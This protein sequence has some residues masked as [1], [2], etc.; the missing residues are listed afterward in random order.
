MA[1]EKK[2]EQPEVKD[3]PEAKKEENKE[4]NKDVEALSKKIESLSQQLSFLQAENSKLKEETEQWKNKYYLAFADL[5]NTRKTIE[6][7]HETFVKYRSQ[8]FLEKMLPALD[9]FEMALMAEPKDPAI[10]NYY[11]G[12][13]MIL[14]QLEEA[15]KNEGVTTIVPKKGDK[16]DAN[17]MHAIQTVPGDEDET[18]AQVYTKGYV[19]LD[20]MIRPAMVVVYKKPEV[21]KEEVKSE[22]KKEEAK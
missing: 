13:K 8:G 21:K 11:K 16:F 6:K 5:A 9:S 1:E 20:R 18:V 15:L 19:L 10:N 22:E 3:S 17:T 14:S 7:D 4:A 12:F 2:A